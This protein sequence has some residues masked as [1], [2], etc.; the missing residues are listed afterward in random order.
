MNGR[1][2]QLGAGN[3]PEQK[4]SERLI[5]IRAGAL[6][7]YSHATLRYALVVPFPVPSLACGGRLGRGQL[8]ERPHPNPPPETGGGRTTSVEEPLQ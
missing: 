6:L 7:F 2:G 4:Q 1:T 5:A 8:L 3:W